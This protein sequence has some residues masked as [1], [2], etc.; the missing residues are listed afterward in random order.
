[1]RRDTSTYKLLVFQGWND[2]GYNNPDMRTP[3]LD[4]LAA[5]GVKLVNSY[6][7]PYGVQ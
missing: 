6:V 1:M 4:S 5:A 7:Q 2:I 3:F